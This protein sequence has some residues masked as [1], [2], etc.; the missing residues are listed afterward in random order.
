MSD[1]EETPQ[2]RL[3][4][5]NDVHGDPIDMP[6]SA[7]AWRVR[8][9]SGKPGRPHNV[10]DVD[11]KQLEIP[12]TST[13]DDLRENGCGPG[14][15]RLEA[16]SNDGRLIGGIVAFTEILDDGTSTEPAT[17]AG[18]SVGRLLDTVE[19]QSDTLCRALEAMAN[20]FGPVAPA[21]GPIAVGEPAGESMRPDQFVAS[22][23]TAAKSFADVCKTGIG[24]G[25]AAGESDPLAGQRRQCLSQLTQIA[26]EL[27][28]TTLIQLVARRLGSREAVIKWFQSLPQADDDGHEH[29]RYISCDV[30]QRTRLLPDDP[31]C[32]ERALG[33]L[34]LLEAIDG[35]T[36]RALAR[37]NGRCGIPASSRNTASIGS[38][39]ICFL[40]VIS[41]GEV[42]ARTCCKAFTPTSASRFSS[43]TG[44]AASPTRW[45]KRK[46]S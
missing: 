43:F 1:E 5:A 17:A 40:A 10:Y 42:S 20:A 11:G 35:Q 4:L 30:P 25:S 12:L 6:A 22:V 27:A 24:G 41:I 26:C 16:V 39:S 19:R 34:M 37:S 8:R 23:A 13:V 31:N 44:S 9:A 7:V 32:V 2:T 38:P 18:D 21:M 28:P 45:A 14:R 3:P 15:Y 29:V 36:P 46:T 33:A